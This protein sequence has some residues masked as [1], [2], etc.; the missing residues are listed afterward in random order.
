MKSMPSRLMLMPHGWPEFYWRV[1]WTGDAEHTQERLQR[2]DLE[3]CM[4]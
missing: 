1:R 3:S 4:K 2:K